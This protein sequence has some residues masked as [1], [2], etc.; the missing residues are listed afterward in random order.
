VAVE[1]V[2]S[3]ITLA[4]AYF[5]QIVVVLITPAVEEVASHEVE[6]LLQAV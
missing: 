4:L 2:E 5:K 3:R 6:D 1:T